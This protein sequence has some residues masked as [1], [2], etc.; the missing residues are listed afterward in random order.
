MPF[1]RAPKKYIPQF[2]G[3]CVVGTAEGEKVDVDPETGEVVNGRLYL[4]YNA[5]VLGRDNTRRAASKPS[6]PV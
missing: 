4:N 3:F 6:R 1:L 2:G 5:Q